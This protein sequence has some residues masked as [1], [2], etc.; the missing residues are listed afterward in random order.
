MKQIKVRCRDLLT[1]FNFENEQVAEINEGEIL[2]AELHEESE[3]YY[4]TDSNGR[5]VYVGCLNVDGVLE[6]D[7]SFELVEEGADKH[8]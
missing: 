2:E 4:A 7:E 8:D 5:E 6:L 3:E 1:V